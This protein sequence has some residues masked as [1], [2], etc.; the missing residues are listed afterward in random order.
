MNSTCKRVNWIDFPCPW[1]HLSS[2]VDV[3][4]AAVC[5]LHNGAKQK[6]TEKSIRL[7]TYMQFIVELTFERWH[8]E[9]IMAGIVLFY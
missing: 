3:S 5:C 1:S 9:A 7:V 4:L 2:M 6:H 8:C